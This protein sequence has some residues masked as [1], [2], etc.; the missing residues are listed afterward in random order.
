MTNPFVDME[1]HPNSPDNAKSFYGDLL[2]W[3]FADMDMGGE[4]YTMINSGAEPFAGVAPANGA[5]PRWL[6]YLGVEDLD[7]AAKKAQ[8]L[9]AKVVL[10]RVDIPAGSFVWIEDP[11]GATVALFQSKV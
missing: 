3:K 6:P 10:P 7:A 5:P 9:G 11:A 4:T 1:L 2:G 8:K